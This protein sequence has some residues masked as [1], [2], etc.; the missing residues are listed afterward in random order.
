MFGGLR[1]ENGHILL[2]FG[3]LYDH[4]I[5]LCS[6][7]TFLRFWYHAPKNLATMKPTG[8]GIAGHLSSKRVKVPIW[9]KNA[10]S[11]NSKNFLSHLSSGPPKKI[12]KSSL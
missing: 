2:T 7:G 11:K 10:L 4:L 1:L 6:F 3:I 12:V 5:I 9:C 8:S